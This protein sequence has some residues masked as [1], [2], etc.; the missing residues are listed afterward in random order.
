MKKLITELNET[1]VCVVDTDKVAKAW[2]E[3]EQV[4]DSVIER[5]SRKMEIPDLT[6]C[7]ELVVVKNS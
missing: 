3:F 7:H 6:E 1:G 5:Y 2:T 4:R